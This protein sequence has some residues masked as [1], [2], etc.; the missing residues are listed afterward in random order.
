MEREKV[1]DRTKGREREV[2]SSWERIWSWKRRESEEWKWCW[3]RE[4]ERERESL[5]VI[6][7][8]CKDPQVLGFFFYKNVILLIFNENE[9][10]KNVYSFSIF[11]LIFLDAKMKSEY[12]RQG[13]TSILVMDPKKTKN[14]NKIHNFFL[15]TKKPRFSHFWAII[16]CITYQVLNICFFFFFF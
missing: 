15:L 1:N 11:K 5:G 9:N 7:E 14:E 13:Q 4:G 6:K 8:K 3:E 12:K 10:S 16:C 2:L